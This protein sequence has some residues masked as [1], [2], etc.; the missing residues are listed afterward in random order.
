V[1]EEPATTTTGARSELLRAERWSRENTFDGANFDAA[2][3]REMKGDSTISVVIPVKEAA[4]TVGRVAASCVLLR[5]AGAIDEVI[6]IDADSQDKSALAASDAGAE[7]HQE[8]ELL[9]EHGAP[10]GKGDALWRGLSVASGDVIVFVDADSEA[11]DGSFVTGLAGP[12][13]VD[14]KLQLVKG[15]FDRPFTSGGVRIEGGGGRVNELVAR[16]LL[17]MYFPELAAVRQPLAG[18]IAARRSA[19]VE[20]PFFSGYGI[21]IQLLI[22]FYKR[23]GLDAIG[24]S[25][26]GE[27]L[28]RHQPL[29]E[30]APMAFSV[31]SAL[32][33]RVDDRSAQPAS[34]DFLGYFDGEVGFRNVLPESRPPLASIGGPHGA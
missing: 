21:E 12:L 28:N 14:D 4:F 18:E 5:D 17:N 13:L 11:F 22:D 10:A 19:L 34:G 7:V 24:Q 16:P 33:S 15:A 20:L 2:R 26:L 1:S 8:S 6:V 32:L 3:L 30:L 9:P 23:F 29:Q 25:D 27:R 31:L